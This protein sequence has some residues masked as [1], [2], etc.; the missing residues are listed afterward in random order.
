MTK[1]FLS[2][3]LSLVL[4]LTVVIQPTGATDSTNT[5]SEFNFELLQKDD[6]IVKVKATRDNGDELYAT[7]DKNTSEVTME[8]VEKQQQNLFSI[9]GVTEGGYETTLYTVDI[10]TLDGPIVD[11]TITSVDTGEVFKI[12]DNVDRVSAQLPALIP[13]VQWGGSALLAWLASHALSMTIAGITAYVI[14][15]IAADIKKNKQYNYWPAWIRK[16]DIYVGGEA[17]KS[18]RDAFDWIKKKNSG[19]NSVFARTSSK[20]DQAARAV[21]GLSKYNSE[22]QGVE[23]HYPHYHP[24]E[25]DRI[26][27]FKNH[28]WFLNGT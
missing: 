12:S 25:P 23:G 27:Q 9:L 4:I 24:L 22:H 26:T 3:L 21:T 8:A 13:V 5:D 2:I 14:T 15:D 11:A 7:M 16:N 20:A 6:N 28:A 18:D 19:E 10:E 1:K 17:F